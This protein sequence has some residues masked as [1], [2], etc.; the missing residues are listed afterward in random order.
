MANTDSSPKL[1]DLLTEEIGSTYKGEFSI[2]KSRTQITVQKNTA[3]AEEGKIAS[4]GG[5]E[6]IDDQLSP[7]DEVR[8][9]VQDASIG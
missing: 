9:S 1:H 4:P 8:I 3:T 6:H 7:P 5:T 2:Q